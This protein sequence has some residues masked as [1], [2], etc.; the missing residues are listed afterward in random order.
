M[1][2]KDTKYG[3]L[4]GQHY[5]GSIDINGLDVNDWEG[6]P[7]S[8]WGSFNANGCSFKDF[9]NAPLFKQ[10]S[11]LF[12]G[13]NPLESLIDMKHENDVS[14]FT[15]QN[16]KLLSFNG[17]PSK[18]RG[19]FHASNIKT[20]K[21]IQGLPTYVVGRFFIDGSNIKTLGNY[22]P[23]KNPI[24]I[25]ME[26][27]LEIE[28][29][30]KLKVKINKKDKNIIEAIM[31]DITIKDKNKINYMFEFYKPSY[32]KEPI[33]QI[34]ENITK[35]DLEIFSKYFSLYENKNIK[36]MLS[37]LSFLDESTIKHLYISSNKSP[38]I[39]L[40]LVKNTNCPVSILNDLKKDN[41]SFQNNDMGIK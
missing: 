28:F 37:S 9:K 16:S 14:D 8:F 7:K 6:C 30:E 39:L 29:K 27:H 25:I 19:M 31:N 36:I 38:E 23:E 32:L 21:S 33:F 13:N 24:M 18:I 34:K 1:K 17:A 5:S 22:T 2:F 11:D 40:N 15:V 3:D 35:K 26:N 4:S 20:L 12:F 41:I 10:G